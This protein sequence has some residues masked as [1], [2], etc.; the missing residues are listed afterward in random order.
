MDINQLKQLVTQQVDQHRDD[1]IAFGEKIYH[2]P[3]TG[4]KEVKTTQTVASAL[5]ELGLPV[6]KNIAVTGCR[7]RGNQDK[8]G[9]K[10][11]I[12]GELDSVLCPE[13][14]D[15][16]PNT[17]A[18]H[19]C[20]HNIQLSTMY[21]VALALEKAGAWDYLDG[22]ID[23]MAVPAEE[24]I[25][26]DYRQDLKNKGEITYYSGKAELV[27]RGVFD[28]VDISMMIHSFPIAAD[29][30]KMAPKN[31]GNGFIGKMV[32]FIGKQAHA[33][34]APWD[35]I[36]ALN[37]ASVAINSIQIQR[38]TFKEQ[39]F[40]RIHQIITKGGDVVNSV[41][42][43]VKMEVTVRARNVAALKEANEKVNRSIK[44]A[45]I[46]LGGKAHI[47]DTPGQ[48]PLIAD[49]IIADLFCENGKQYY[50]E[51]EILPCMESTASFDMG[52][53]SQF[54]PVLHGITSGISGGL[55]SSNYRIEDKEDAYITPVKILACTL[56]DLLYNNAEKSQQVLENFVPTLSRQEYLQTIADMEREITYE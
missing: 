28:D 46:A 22:Q 33:G 8:S 26:L 52:D 31:T 44:G 29:G 7:A 34:A 12:L 35:G 54:M 15:S 18:M 42:A 27:E 16:D 40:V 10:I 43:D 41:P 6:E 11:A 49:D 14:P 30:W 21:G 36:N 47:V 23:F 20:G 56:I 3:E 13:H 39:D 55:H 24:Y 4:Y 9:P 25:Q 53:L 48:M 19:A 45:A 2:N 1:I 5:E 32:N 50:D 17:G 38:E 37:M 51:K